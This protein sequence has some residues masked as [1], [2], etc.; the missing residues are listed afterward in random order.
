MLFGLCQVSI[1]S[2]GSFSGSLAKFLC[3][4]F[5]KYAPLYPDPPTPR[6][7]GAKSGKRGEGTFGSMPQVLYITN[8]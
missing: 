3:F 4:E 1:F 7:R 6:K 2:T 8:L 5:S